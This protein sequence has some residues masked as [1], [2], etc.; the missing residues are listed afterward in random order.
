MMAAAKSGSLR[1]LQI[2][3]EN[4]ADLDV[5]NKDGWNALHIAGKGSNFTLV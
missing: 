1:V 4:G 3:V 5:T 2:L